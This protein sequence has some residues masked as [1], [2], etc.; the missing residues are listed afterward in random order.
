MLPSDIAKEHGKKVKTYSELY[1]RNQLM[2][3]A[4]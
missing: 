2:I 3:I 1:V 4:L